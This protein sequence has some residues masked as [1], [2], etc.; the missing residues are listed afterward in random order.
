MRRC[1]WLQTLPSATRFLLT[2]S[3]SAICLIVLNPFGLSFLFLFWALLLSHARPCSARF[4]ARY[5]ALLDRSRPLTRSVSQRPC[6]LR[7]VSLLWSATFTVS[8]RR[9]PFWTWDR[10]DCCDT[11][12]S[13]DCPRHLMDAIKSNMFDA[14]VVILDIAQL[15]IDTLSD[16][17]QRPLTLHCSGWLGF[18]AW[19]VYYACFVTIGSK[20]SLRWCRV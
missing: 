4:L 3:E 6:W 15:G 18:A 7:P 5:C 14:F 16:S 1:A 20:A 10:I 2:Y 8:P 13:R 11:T 17:N 19:L 9:A 12:A